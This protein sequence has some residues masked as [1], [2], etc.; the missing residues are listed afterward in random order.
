[1]CFTLK[2]DVIRRTMFQIIRRLMLQ[3]AASQ[4]QKLICNTSIVTQICS[5]S[6]DNVCWDFRT[7]LFG[8]LLDFY[9]FLCLTVR[10]NL[11]LVRTRVQPVNSTKNTG[12]TRHNPV[13]LRCCQLSR[14]SLPKAPDCTLIWMWC[15]RATLPLLLKV[16]AAL[17]FKHRCD[18]AILP[19]LG[20]YPTLKPGV[21]DLKSFR[22]Y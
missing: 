18:R 14:P 22:I 13:R 8:R 15:D 3:L 20:I 12:T 4:S 1:M 7:F 9:T 16:P 5:K 10:P 6:N 17:Q 19:Q 11:T 21:V 2:V